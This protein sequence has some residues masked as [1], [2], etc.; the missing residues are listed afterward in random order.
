MID[1][2]GFLVHGLACHQLLDHF[3]QVYLLVR[4]LDFEIPGGLSYQW[5]GG[6]YLLHT[7]QCSS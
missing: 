5:G 7:T 2:D 4:E 1:M 6:G 3:S